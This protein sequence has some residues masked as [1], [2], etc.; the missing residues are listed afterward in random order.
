MKDELKILMHVLQDLRIPL[1]A[2]AKALEQIPSLESR[3]EK[4]LRLEKRMEKI[5]QAKGPL[6]EIEE[7]LDNVRF[8][9]RKAQ[10]GKESLAKIA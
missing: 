3:L 8:I 4:G 2:E 1:L 5:L 6:Y 10:E 9:V 7:A